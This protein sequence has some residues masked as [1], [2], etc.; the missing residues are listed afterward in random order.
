MKKVIVSLLTVMTVVFSTGC[1]GVS[2]DEYYSLV[3]E[4]SQL[5][6]TNAS[7]LSEKNNLE[8]EYDALKT[9]KEA[10]EQSNLSSDEINYC[11]DIQTWMLGRPQSSIV[12]NDVE[13]YGDDVDL[14]TTYYMENSN[15]TIKM[16]HTI[17]E[18]LSP[19]LTAIHIFSYEK[20][21]S[22]NIEK[23]LDDELKEYMIIYRNYNEG[24]GSVIARSF[25]YLDENNVI[26]HNLFFTKYGVNKGI[27]DEYEKLEG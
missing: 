9:E 13:K 1:S 4:N 22:N 12:K 5:K 8:K 18:T 19:A 16:V 20:A 11:F 7:I 3:E 14:E 17:K 2:Q 24:Y 10:L 6:A 25:Y 21:T 23:V 27:V 26:R 15:F